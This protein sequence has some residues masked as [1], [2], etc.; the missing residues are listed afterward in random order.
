MPWNTY[1]G[2]RATCESCPF[3]C[4]D[5]EDRP[6]VVRLSRCLYLLSSLCGSEIVFFL[7]NLF[8]FFVVLTIKWEAATI[9]STKSCFRSLYLDLLESPAK[10]ISL[11][12]QWNILRLPLL[13][14]TQSQSAMVKGSGVGAELRC[15]CRQRS[16][17]PLRAVWTWAWDRVP[18]SLPLRS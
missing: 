5:S 15:W 4:V 6:Q 7:L 17:G 13:T 2:Q 18:H 1:G 8:F 11:E 14:V 16:R 9:L 12:N 3:F 10:V